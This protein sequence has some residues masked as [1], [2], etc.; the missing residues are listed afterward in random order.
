MNLYHVTKFSP[1]FSC[2]V[3]C[4]YTRI[5]SFMPVLSIRIVLDCF[6]LL[7]FY[8]EKFSTHVCRLPYA[9]NVNLILSNALLWTRSSSH[10]K[11]AICCALLAPPLATTSDVVL[12]STYF[13]SWE[14]KFPLRLRSLIKIR[15]NQGPSF[16]P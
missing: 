5:S 15:N 13:Q 12:S 16:V 10:C 8:F 4:L 14:L 2:T 7:I 3:H 11:S 1:Y 6:Y 9:A